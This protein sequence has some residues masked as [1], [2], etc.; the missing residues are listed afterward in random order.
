MKK[1]KS[2]STENRGEGRGD[3]RGAVPASAS[4]VKK[5]PGSHR[6]SRV[7]GEMRDVIANYLLLT[8]RRD[9]PGMVTVTR[10]IV[11]KDLRA[12]KVL[13]TVMDPTGESGL[14]GAA[15]NKATLEV[16]KAQAYEVQAEVNSKLKMRYTPV[17]TFFHDDGFDNAMKVEN[18]LNEITRK[19]LAEEGASDQSESGSEKASD[20]G[21]DE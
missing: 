2:T 7:E 10:V 16:L 1:Y 20:A 17:L 13:F 6:T 21:G 19:R 14:E 9:L 12:A 5:E 11:A 18:I 8:L 3:G 15:L 4:A